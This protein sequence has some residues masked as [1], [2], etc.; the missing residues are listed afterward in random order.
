[1]GRLQVGKL[2][3][4]K[5]CKYSLHVFENIKKIMQGVNKSLLKLCAYT[6]CIDNAVSKDSNNIYSG[7][8]DEDS[9][10]EGILCCESVWGV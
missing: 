1:M 10:T 7:S 2:P 3:N 8:T 9:D 6:L 5:V 4:Q